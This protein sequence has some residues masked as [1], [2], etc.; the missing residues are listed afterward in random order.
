MEHVTV[1]TTT[2]GKPFA[3]DRGGREWIVGAEPIRWYERVNWWET[4]RRM[5]I[6]G[7]LAAQVEVW[8]VQARIGR[9]PRTPLRTMELTR[10]LT[11]AGWKLRAES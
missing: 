9:N 7:G 8:R 11:G 4:E 1:R 5:P 10:D 2:T 6:G 3:I